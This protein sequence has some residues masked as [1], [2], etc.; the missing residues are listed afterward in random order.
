MKKLFIILL[1]PLSVYS[2]TQKSTVDSIRVI[3]FELLNQ[4]RIDNNLD[5][6]I[7]SNTHNEAAQ[8]RAKYMYDNNDYSHD[9][10]DNYIENIASARDI[11]MYFDFEARCFRIF[12]GWKKSPGHNRNYLDH[13]FTHVGFG[14]YKGYSVVLFSMK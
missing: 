9:Y 7:I 10:T 6:L 14:S 3:F 12:N 4:H 13:E 8:S 5:T 1:L 2:Q 11:S